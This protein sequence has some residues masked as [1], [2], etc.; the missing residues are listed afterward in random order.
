MSRFLTQLIPL[1]LFEE[2]Q[3]FFAQKNYN[4][5]FI[6]REDFPVSKLTIWG[7]PQKELF[8]E[9]IQRMSGLSFGTPTENLVSQDHVYESVRQFN[10]RYAIQDPMHVEFSENLIARCK[11]TFNT[12]SFRLPLQ[13]TPETFDGLYRHELETHILRRANH[14]L[15]FPNQEFTEHWDYRRTEEGL[16]NLH[17]HLFL[18]DKTIKKTYLSYVSVYLSQNFSFAEA[19]RQLVELRIPEDK[20]W[21]LIVRTKRGMTDTS[22]PGG[23]TKDI[24]YL[25]GTLMV[26]NWLINKNGNPHDLYLGR[27]GLEDVDRFKGTIDTSQ[28]FYPS[29]FED[30]DVYNKS[31]AEIGEANQFSILL[32]K[33]KI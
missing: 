31:I 32:Q 25:E 28:S 5:Q 33:L 17:S 6:Y 19:F 13:Y 8:E 24:C 16:A 27:L 3:K 14:L 7:F 1:N 18:S 22:Q 11:V 23:L 20:A 26:W 9:A 29:F 12:I 2:K 15:H 21:N 4:P 10:Q 30:M